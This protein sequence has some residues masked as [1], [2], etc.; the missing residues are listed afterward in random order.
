MYENMFRCGIIETLLLITA[1]MV[2][3]NLSIYLFT[4]CWFF[5][6]SYNYSEIWTNVFDSKKLSFIPAVLN[7]LS[8]MTYISW[9][10][11]EIYECAS[12]FF[13]TV[14]PGCPSFICNKYFL[15]YFFNFITTLPC[16][17]VSNFTS[18]T[19][20]AYIGNIAMIIS[21]ICL[22]ILLI[23]SIKN[24]RF[25]MAVNNSGS[26]DDESGFPYLTY[27]TLFSKDAS[28]LFGCI[29][30]VMSAFYMHPFLEMIFEKY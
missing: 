7:I 16:L 8:Y 15:M 20:I 27:I 28:A 9:F 25:S 22:L 10:N 19:I 6:T 4:R 24:I 30:T 14:W 17:F 2:L 21:V 12:I 13:Q 23:K 18:F 3:I 26:V 1:V 5:G 29:G 11:F